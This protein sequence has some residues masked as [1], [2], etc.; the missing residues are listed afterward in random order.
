[1]SS[2]E[3]KIQIVQVARKHFAMHGYLGASLKDIAAEA[4]VASSL[5]NYHFRDKEG[6]FHSCMSHFA[7]DR[8]ATI[9]RVLGEVRN[10]QEVHLRLQL[11]V[12]EMLASMMDDPYGFDI[13]QREVRAGNPAVI[14]L[15]QETLLVAFEG[16]VD[17]FKATQSMGVLRPEVDPTMAALLLFSTTGELAR[18]D[19]LTQK[20]LNVSLVQEE[21]R[22]KFAEHVVGL[23]MNG[24][25]K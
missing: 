13:I 17:F 4:D 18:L 10:R 8:V 2:E 12:E 25:M 6:L 22:K 24:V 23:F 3:L 19:V 20:F 1:M 21:W 14:H 9:R 15:F 16:V 7:R 5:I 11:F